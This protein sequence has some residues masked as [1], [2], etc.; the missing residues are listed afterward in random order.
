MFMNRTKMSTK[1]MFHNMELWYHSMKRIEGH[2][3]ST[4]GTYFKFLRWLFIVNIILLII[5]FGFIVI[6]QI[7]YNNIAKP[8]SSDNSSLVQ[9]QQFQFED[10]L[11]AQ[12]CH[13]CFSLI[14]FPFT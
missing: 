11:T 14:A 12:V 10:L 4:V 1:N 8:F 2:F 7:I 3:G 9:N 5:T 13:W 6:P